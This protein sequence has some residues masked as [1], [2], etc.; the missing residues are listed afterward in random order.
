MLRML[1][2]HMKRI[3]INVKGKLTQTK[4][5]LSGMQSFFFLN[6]RGGRE[7]GIEERKRKGERGK[8]KF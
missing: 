6:W 3:K 1:V 5:Y 2:L 8:G 7:L 4:T